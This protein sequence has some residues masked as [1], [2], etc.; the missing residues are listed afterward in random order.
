MLGKN[1]AASIKKTS[2]VAF[3]LLGALFALSATEASAMVYTF[4]DG[5]TNDA[6]G[7]FSF[8]TSLSGAQLDNL[9]QGTDIT[10][11]VTSFTFP[12]NVTTQLS[13]DQG[14]FPIGQNNPIPS[15]TVAIGTN[16]VGQ[17]TSWSI[18]EGFFASYPAFPGDSPTDFFASYTV[19]T[20]N[21]G[22]S[23]LLVADNDAGFAPG[24]S[25]N[26]PVSFTTGTGSFTAA[27]A[28]VPEPSTW[29]MMIIGFLGL[30]F[31][32]YR[33]RSQTAFNAV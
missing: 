17:I 30:G 31:M 1:M 21:T 14:G 19:T 15:A 7:N 22:D 8:T 16:A 13:Q 5:N 3:S 28:P 2:L 6:V 32:A 25:P 12:V 20:T 24:D 26:G 29:A 10:S 18:S 11:S 27:V 4:T 9:A 33:R 23:V